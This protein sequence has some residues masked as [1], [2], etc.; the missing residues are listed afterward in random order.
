MSAPIQLASDHSSTDARAVSKLAAALQSDACPSPSHTRTCHAYA[1]AP[2]RSGPAYGTS[3]EEAEST[4]PLSQTSGLD[5]PLS[6][7]A[8]RTW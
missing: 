5:S 4:L 7:V 1:V 2:S 6:L 8:T 3:T